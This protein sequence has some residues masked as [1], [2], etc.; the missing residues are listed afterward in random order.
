MGALLRALIVAFG[1]GLTA[2][3]QPELVAPGAAHVGERTTCPVS[4]QAFVVTDGSPK[5]E[6][7]GKTYYFCCPGCEERFKANPRKYLTRS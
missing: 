2:C 4:K 3:A 7:D 5:V 1:V 6:L